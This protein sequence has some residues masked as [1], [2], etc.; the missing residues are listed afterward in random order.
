M[1][2]R[3][4][5]TRKKLLI[6]KGMYLITVSILSLFIYFVLYSDS[7]SAGIT[8]NLIRL[9]VVAESDS[10]KDQALKLEVRDAIINY[11]HNKLTNTKDIEESKNNKK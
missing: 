5:F 8:E 7:V 3:L 10:K 1:N 11:M 2:K 9:H 4:F 6:K